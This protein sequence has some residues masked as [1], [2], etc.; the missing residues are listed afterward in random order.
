MARS[1]STPLAWL[2]LLIVSIGVLG[3]PA[4]A[5]AQADMD[6]LL[7]AMDRLSLK[8]PMSVYARDPVK[9]S[10]GELARERC[11]QQAIADL[12][13]ALDK[14]GYRREA[15]TAL[16]RFSETCGNHAASLRSA[17]NILL[18]LSD[19]EAAVELASRLIALQPF[20]DNGYFL[21][22]LA[23]DRG[24]SPQRAI[25]DYATAIE[26]FGNKDR[27]SSVGYLGMARSYEKI[28][29]A[30][31]AALAIESWVSI[32]PARNETSQTR[33]IIATYMKQGAC[34]RPAAGGDEVFPVSRPSDQVKLPVVVN[35]TRG[36]FILD[37]GATFVTL[38]NAFAQKAKVQVDD[39]SVVH[40]HTANG[41]A[42]AKRG[43]AATVQLR[44]L[45]AKDVPIV[46]QDDAKGSYGE[47]VDGLLGM[48][49]LSRFKVTV[50]AR[51]VRISGRK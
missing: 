1:G 41:L 36:V 32:N 13:D 4:A 3:P 33:A 27:I 7:A 50:D 46:V 28:G 12:G 37:T 40:M 26:L 20:N 10:L 18:R 35:G 45:A 5:Q 38:R 17:V 44:S 9:R 24:G 47:G 8:L 14:A 22:A 19:Y 23:Y 48:S 31:D 21:R 43:R 2:L 39:D 6:D 51:A 42:T 11:D 25:D 34:E 15:V 16:T 49:F 29:R 30:C